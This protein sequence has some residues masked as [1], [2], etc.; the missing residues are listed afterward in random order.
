VRG[1]VQSLRTE[2]HSFKTDVAKEFGAV[3]AENGEFKSEVT[4]ELG[5]LRTAIV[6][7]RLWMLGTGITTVLSVAAIVGLKSH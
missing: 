4:K 7:A 1:E 5:L 2:V 3:R 6:Q